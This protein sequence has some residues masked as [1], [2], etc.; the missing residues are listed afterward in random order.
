MSD[1]ES[2]SFTG[3]PTVRAA[4][5]AA[6][7]CGH[8]RSAA[9]KPPPVNGQRTRTSAGSIPKTR[10]RW[11]RTPSTH[12][13]VSWIVSWDPS[14]LATV[15]MRPIG[16]WGSIGVEYRS[17]RRTSADSEAG[18]GG[19]V[20]A[21]HPRLHQ[22]GVRLRGVGHLDQGA[23]I[24]GLLPALRDHDRDRLTVEQDPVVLEHAQIV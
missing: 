15:V 12:W 6:T 23:G 22:R 8:A 5:A 9:P 7:T 10:A 21:A 11:S 1:R 19:C 17:S 20:P 16:L 3:R 4:I 24:P 18:G 14:Q 2:T 13:V